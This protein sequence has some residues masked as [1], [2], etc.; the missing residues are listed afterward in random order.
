MPRKIIFIHRILIEPF[1][2]EKK[3]PH[4]I[5]KI[6]FVYYQLKLFELLETFFCPGMHN[7]VKIVIETM[8]KYALMDI[9]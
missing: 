2:N 3:S 6:S 5:F 4:F 8:Y 9:L 1:E 7:V